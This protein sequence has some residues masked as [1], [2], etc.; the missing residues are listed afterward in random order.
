MP[1]QLAG[2]DNSRVPNPAGGSGC[3][4]I[5]RR[6]HWWL[7]QLRGPTHHERMSQLLCRE[8]ANVPALPNMRSQGQGDIEF[9]KLGVKYPRVEYEIE[10]SI[11]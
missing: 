8:K 10:I 3:V 5:N 11:E 9:P 4:G 7:A 6:G 2:N 1:A